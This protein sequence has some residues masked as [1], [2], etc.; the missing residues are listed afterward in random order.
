RW[1]DLFFDPDEIALDEIDLASFPDGR[2]LQRAAQGLR[3]GSLDSLAIWDETDVGQE[4]V[5]HGV[6]RHCGRPLRK[7]PAQSGAIA[8]ALS[9]AAFLGAIVW[10]D[11]DQIVDSDNRQLANEVVR[12]LTRTSTPLMLTG[13]LPWRPPALLVR[14][15]YAEIQ[16]APPDEDAR[17]RSWRQAMPD[18]SESQARTLSQ[19]YRLT[20]RSVLAAKKAAETQALLQSNGTLHRPL[21]ELDEMCTV[22]SQ[23]RGC[24][25]ARTV[26]PKRGPEELVL[27]AS[28]HTQVLEIA[29]FYRA[30]TQVNQRWGFANLSTGAGGIKALFSGDS[31][32]GKSLAAEVIAHEA[33]L[34]MLKVDLSQVVSKWIGETEKNIDAAFCE[35]ETRHALLFFDEADTLYGKRGEVQR[36]SDRYANLEVG[37]LLQRLD[38]FAG[39]AVLATNLHDQIDQAFIRRL[40]VVLH[41]PRPAQDE[42]LRLWRMALPQSAPVEAGL[43]VADL[44]HLD[45]TGASIFSACH[46]AALLAADEESKEIGRRHIAEGIARQF[47][48][49]SRILGQSDLARFL[50]QSSAPVTHAVR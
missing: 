32:T 23:T 40:Q 1:N 42:R 48:R 4:A 18:I 22:M 15:R 46:T 9:Q 19:R 50:R 8:D 35:A 7:L 21:D 30:L 38:Q 11:A 36:G 43:N 28:L 10:I 25:F 12:H 49:E 26:F 29:R 20:P 5:A 14:R 47:H 3:E 27:P 24:R 44:V 45:M 17:T 41:F 34:P 37:Y 2:Q 16:L 31:G 13:R 33:G 6:A 39:L